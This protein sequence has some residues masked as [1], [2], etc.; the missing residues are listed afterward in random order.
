MSLLIGFVIYLIAAFLTI[1]VNWS[2]VYE[3]LERGKKFV[4]AF[5]NPDFTS[6]SSDIWEGMLESIIMT[7]AAS[8]VGMRCTG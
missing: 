8:V 3:G 7:V 6:R 2:R 1:D 4:L 5:A